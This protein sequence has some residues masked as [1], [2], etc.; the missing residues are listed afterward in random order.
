MAKTEKG[1]KQIILRIP[2]EMYK[3]ATH[4]FRIKGNG[5]KDYL[6]DLIRKSV[7]IKKNADYDKDSIWGVVGLG[8]S[9]AGD[10][11]AKHDTYLYGSRGR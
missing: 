7:T 1:Y 10:L 8:R 6:M 5:L 3:K 9:K 2:E 4:T 11:S